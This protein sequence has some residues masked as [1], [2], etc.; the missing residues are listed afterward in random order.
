MYSS[1]CQKCTIQ[2]IIVLSASLSESRLSQKCRIIVIKHCLKKTCNAQKAWNA[3]M[4]FLP[5]LLS[6]S[7]CSILGRIHF[8]WHTACFGFFFHEDILLPVAEGQVSALSLEEFL[9]PNLRLLGFHCDIKVLE[10][11]K[12][13]SPIFP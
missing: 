3:P 6:L 2:R 13:Q 7:V 10:Q 8:Q 12:Q 1:L 9:S 5:S 4:G 11:S